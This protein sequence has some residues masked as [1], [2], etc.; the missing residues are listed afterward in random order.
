MKKQTELEFIK[1]CKIF[2]KTLRNDPELYYSY[3]SAIAMA[4]VDNG[5]W[6]N[7]RD[8]YKKRHE[9]GNKAAKYFLDLLIREI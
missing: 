2:T 3:Q 9:I 5:R 6:S 8:S 4:Y 1:A 7:S